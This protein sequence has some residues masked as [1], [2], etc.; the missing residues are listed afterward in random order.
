MSDVQQIDD[1]DATLNDFAIDV[2]QRHHQILRAAIERGV[3]STK[4][5]T[6]RCTRQ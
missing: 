2:Q 5:S 6:G 4:G 1:Q 3:Y